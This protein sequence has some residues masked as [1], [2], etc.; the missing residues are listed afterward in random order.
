MYFEDKVLYPTCK[1]ACYFEG[2]YVK[3]VRYRRGS[4]YVSDLIQGNLW[5]QEN[6]LTVYMFDGQYFSV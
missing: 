1:K 5:G 2:W 3:N 4:E 6:L